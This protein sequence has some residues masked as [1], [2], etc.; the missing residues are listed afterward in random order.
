MCF[1]HAK[2]GIAKASCLSFHLSVSLCVTL[3]CRDHIDWNSD[4]IISRL[5]TI[6]ISVSADLNMM[7]LLQREHLQMYD[8][9]VDILPAC[10]HCTV[11][12]VT[13]H[14]SAWFV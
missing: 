5:I 9:D 8:L 7:D 1:Y 3:S 12:I 2:C 11:A 14:S 10:V 4:K 6:T 13:L